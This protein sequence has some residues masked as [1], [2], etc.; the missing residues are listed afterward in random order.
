MTP[1]P[2]KWS[3]TVGT[4]GCRVTVATHPRTPMLQIRWWD[5]ATRKTRWRSLGHADRERAVREAKQLASDLLGMY[6]AAAPPVAPGRGTLRQVFARFE[7]DA[8]PHVRALQAREDRRRL[9]IWTAFLGPDAELGEVDP[10]TFDRFIR[11]RRAGKLQVPDHTL[12]PTPSNRAI[13]A[14][15]EFLRR[16]CNWARLVRVA[17]VPLL[18]RNPLHGY[19]VPT[20][21]S[22]KRPLA[23]YDRY[24]AVRAKADEVEQRG[25]FSPFL[26][27][28]EG[29][30]VAGQRGLSAP[31]QRLRHA[32]GW[33]RPLWAHQEAG[34]DGQGRDRDVGA[35][36]GPGA[37]RGGHGDPA[38]WS[39]G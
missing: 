27:L 34:R 9:A 22:P 8:V 16:V 10:T 33:G 23:T 19:R 12:K 29:L 21:P 30:G 18:E 39:S 5:K 1:R 25:L 2:A 11:E 26:D 31:G 3:K 7:R 35:D 24:L 13:A 37:G 36:V 32:A 17:G 15:L 28:I 4:Y 38:H 14:D 6:A 20:N